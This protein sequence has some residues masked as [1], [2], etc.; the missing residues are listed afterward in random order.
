MSKT[1][2]LGVA[3]QWA[4][5]SKGGPQVVVLDSGESVPAASGYNEGDELRPHPDDAGGSSYTCVDVGGTKYWLGVP[6]TAS[7]SNDED[8]S[9]VNTRRHP[10]PWEPIASRKGIMVGE[11]AHW[12]QLNATPATN[13]LDI[14]IEYNTA[15]LASFTTKDL[16]IDTWVR[17]SLAINTVIDFSAIDNQADA[18]GTDH[19]VIYY[20]ENGAQNMRIGGGLLMREIYE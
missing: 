5:A 9:I 1:Y 8:G 17:L 10:I 19:L 6:A 12:N 18:G 4:H 3:P 11:E 14:T 2:A 16:A 15:T 7:V 13:Y 20:L